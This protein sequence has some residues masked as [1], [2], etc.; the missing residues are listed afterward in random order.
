MKYDPIEDFT[1]HDGRAPHRVHRG[2]PCPQCGRTQSVKPPSGQT[3][4]TYWLVN[5]FVC[6]HCGA[7]VKIVVGDD[8]RW[9]LTV[10]TAP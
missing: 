1:Q 9:D 10:M 6:I 7:Q 2:V 4:S 5:F 8:G 3:S